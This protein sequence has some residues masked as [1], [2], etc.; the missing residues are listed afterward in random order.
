MIFKDVIDQ[1]GVPFIAHLKTKGEYVGIDWVA[2]K[3]EDKDCFGILLPLSVGSQ[4]V[5]ESLTYAENGVFSLK[6]QKLLT[7]DTL[8]TGTLIT[9]KGRTYTIQD[10]KD[11]SDYTD[12]NI[13]LAR[14]RERGATDESN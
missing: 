4:S 11:L 2:G 9:Y 5:G 3:N 8:P 6:D 7:T 12:V 10:Y 13:Y 1:Q 14:W